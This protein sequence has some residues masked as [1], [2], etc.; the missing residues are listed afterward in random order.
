M[1]PGCLCR[2]ARRRS[3]H[4]LEQHD[5]GDVRVRRGESRAP[6]VGHCL[7]ASATVLPSVHLPQ[8]DTPDVKPEGAAVASLN[9]VLHLRGK[10]RRVTAVADLAGAEAGK[11]YRAGIRQRSRSPLLTDLLCRVRR[12]GHGRDRRNRSNATD[13]RQPATIPRGPC[14]MPRRVVVI[15]GAICPDALRPTP[16]IASRRV[17]PDRCRLV[18]V[19]FGDPGLRPADEIRQS[20][21]SVQAQ[22]R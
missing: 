20:L 5:A 17:A 8:K 18:C 21:Q 13:T 19:G 2:G 22:L 14:L 4:D 9:R 15:N 16:V 12:R 11:R 3:R 6:I 7:R 10:D 1:P